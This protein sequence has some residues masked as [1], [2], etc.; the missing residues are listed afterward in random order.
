MID[1]NNMSVERFAKVFDAAILAPNT[2]EAAVR[3][4]CRDAVAYNINAIYTTPCWTKVVAEELAGSDVQVGVGIG[5]P[6]GTPTVATKMFEIDD[7]MANGAT[8]IDMMINVGALKDGNLELTRAEIKGLADKVKAAPG[9]VSKVIIEVCFLTDEEIATVTKICCEYGIDYVKTATGS[10]GL[11]DVHQVE[12]I[13]ENLSGHTKIKLSGV[14]RQFVL[15]AC[16]RMIEMG[17]ELIGTRSACK[18][19]EEYKAYLAEKSAK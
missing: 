16:L 18:I 2:Q 19:V 6:Y 13:R 9:C 14:P 10:Q 8:A 17:V 15:S 7:A 1:V 3:A 11:P 5:F 12:V 4:M